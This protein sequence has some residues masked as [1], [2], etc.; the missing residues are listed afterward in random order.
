MF[1]AIIEY[2]FFSVH[3][4]LKTVKDDNPLQRA[5]DFCVL[6]PEAYLFAQQQPQSPQQQQQDDYIF[7]AQDL[8]SFFDHFNK[9]NQSDRIF[10]DIIRDNVP[11]KFFAFL[12]F[13]ANLN[14][15]NEE[16]AAMIPEMVS[17]LKSYIVR[18]YKSDFKDQV[19]SE[20]SW[21]EFDMSRNNK[22]ARHLYNDSMAFASLDHLQTF[23]NRLTKTIEN[24][25]KID[26]ET[27]KLVVYR[28]K[29]QQKQKK[30]L[31]FDLSIYSK[32]KKI[33]I[34]WA[35]KLGDYK[36][37]LPVI[38]GVPR[39][40]LNFPQQAILQRCLLTYFPQKPPQSLLLMY[41]HEN[42]SERFALWKNK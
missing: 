12:E 17:L 32:H 38:R 2:R 13:E 36:H 11:I 19:L 6:H 35:T 23:M 29:N 8:P 30:E 39:F 10:E 33:Q 5:I 34:P 20:D 7:Y 3:R 27:L 22:I 40:D 41:K 21:L 18:Q 15:E 16:R 26:E 24:N 25:K 9:L 4:K 31:F 42:I 1:F 14:Q 28:Q 37:L